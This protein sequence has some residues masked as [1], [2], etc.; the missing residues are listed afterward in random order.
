MCIHIR[1]LGKKVL[2]ADHVADPENINKI[3]HTSTSFESNYS[4]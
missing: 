2:S 4:G 1:K 3:L